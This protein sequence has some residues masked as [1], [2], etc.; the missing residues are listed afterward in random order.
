MS[1]AF[2][3]PP[4]TH[5]G[6]LEQR[7]KTLMAF[8]LVMVTTLLL[9][10]VYTDAVSEYLLPFNP[11]Y[12]LI[13]ATYGLTLIHA[14]MLRLLP[15]REAP[16]YGQIIGDLVIVTGLV[17]LTGG[18]RAGF[19]L[20]YPIVVLTG[21][22]LL[23][24]GRGMILA[25][26]ATL[27]YAGLLWLVRI[28]A[29][30]P[31][32]L[33]DIPFLS[34]NSVLYSIFVTGVACA[35]VAFIGSYLSAS[36]RSA[37][38]QL[39]D[40][41]GQVAD[42]QRLNQIIVSSIHSGLM[43]IDGQAA[44]LYVNDYGAAILG[45][46]SSEIRGRPVNEVLGPHLRE[47][48]TRP[49]ED[50]LTRF[51]VRYERPDGVQL[52]LGISVSPLL[53][54]EGG[55]LLVF[56]D[57]TEIKRLERDGRANERLAAVG[58]MAA[59]LAHEIRNPLGSISGSAQVLLAEL[60]DSAITSEHARLLDIIRRESK[61]L[62]ESL[63]QFLR[64]TRPVPAPSQPVDLREVVSNAITLL[65]NGSEVKPEHRIEFEADAG[66][67]L[68]LADS[69][70]MTQVFWNLARNALEAMPRGGCLQIQLSRRGDEVVL[71]V[72][73]EGRG[74]PGD[75]HRAIF[76]PFRSGTSMGTGLGLAIVYRIVRQHRGDITVRSVPAQGT[77]FE[78]H[79]PFAPALRLA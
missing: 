24:R 76:E 14:A 68:C 12:M 40:A 11:F 21:S 17:Y 63:N 53:T 4:A 3:A 36:L 66:P 28:G 2:E 8:R 35:T 78:V 32:G 52:E 62:S 50:R 44:V 41:T 5:D 67:H 34:A 65:R 54:A 30:P 31:Q 57:L 22:V 9:V 37:S 38:E 56:Q 43:T 42:L 20:L 7:L 73:D 51:D 61:R 10:A 45:R 49:V 77:E 79:L 19:T 69:D 25:G 16:V 26:L 59:Q 23:V 48:P 47:A 58:E 60:G 33:Y 18:S 64:E 39:E 71:T 72:R 15:S 55:K 46:R 70:Q 29:I 74:L 75:D 13:G 6:A 27:F 1:I